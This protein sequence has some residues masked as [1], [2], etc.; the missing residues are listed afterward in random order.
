MNEYIQENS[1]PNLFCETFFYEKES[2]EIEEYAVFSEML[3]KTSYHSLRFNHNDQYLA[4]GTREGTIRIYNITT[5]NYTCELN[6]NQDSKPGTIQTLR[7]RP[8]MEGRT[9]NILM[10]ACKDQLLEWHTPSRKIVSKIQ[11]PD[12][13]ECV[14]YSDDGSLIAVGCTSSFIMIYDALTKKE[15]LK[16]GG[17]DSKV[18]G[19]SNKVKALKFSRLDPRV[20]ISAGDSCLLFWDLNSIL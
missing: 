14:E 18:T 10:T 2:I 4:A 5:N 1:E 13:V 7:W 6:C 19:H 3:G 9:N 15:L 8:K 17:V 12:V 16:L 11:V 20:L